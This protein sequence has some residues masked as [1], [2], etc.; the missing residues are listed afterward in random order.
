MK[1]RLDELLVRKK[2]ATTRSQAK[3]LVEEGSVTYQN[4]IIQKPGFLVEETASVKM[5]AQS[6]YVGRGAKKLEAAIQQFQINLKNKVIADVGASTGGFTDYLL[7]NGAKKIY[8]IDVGSGQLAEKLRQ[9]PRVVNMEG[10]NIR[11][12]ETLPET[13]E[14]A[15]IDLSFISL[16]LVLKN[17]AALLKPDAQIIALIKPQ[18]EA[19]PK[20]VGKDGVIKD[21]EKVQE[22]LTNFL[23][24]CEK[25]G[26]KVHQTIDSPITGKQGNKEFLA[27]ISFS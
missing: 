12:L 19:G 1:I 10:T 20:V 5:T 23:K 6:N 21:P 9:D 3:Q 27:L 16:R 22:V 25:E 4:R 14:L 11:N 17:V 2:L 26:F 15:V 7:Q 24:W 8:A 18:F 13:P